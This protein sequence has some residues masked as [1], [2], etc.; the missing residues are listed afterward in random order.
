MKIFMSI[1]LFV[2]LFAGCS[3]GKFAVS[4]VFRKGATDN[5]QLLALDSTYHFYLREVY[6]YKNEQMEN[7]LK[8]NVDKSDTANKTRIE[9]EYL[10]LSHVHKNAVYIST[11]P[12]RY[13]HYYSNN[14]VAD[15]LINAYD[16]NM[17][18]FGKIADDGESIYFTTPK[19][20]KAITWDIRPF[21]TDQ[22]PRKIFIR[23]I[24]IKRKEVMENVIIIN[25]ALEQPLAFTRQ[26]NFTI[27]FES[28]NNKSDTCDGLAG[29]CKVSDQKIYFLREKHGYDLLFRFD[30]NIPNSKD[31]AIRFNCSKIRYSLLN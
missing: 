12:D 16:F 13:Q 11:I 7:V 2:L 25:S 31:S 17:F 27:I 14:Q 15:T 21:I 8:T 4:D 28:A 1:L 9:V 18:H 5:I 10:L 30:K 22:F 26:K 29:L 3:R 6:K 23:E 19:G 20:E 24:A